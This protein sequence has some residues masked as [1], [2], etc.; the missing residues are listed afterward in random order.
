MLRTITWG[1][2]KGQ[3]M[4]PEQAA[5]YNQQYP[6]S[7]AEY[8]Q[9]QQANGLSNV[10]I[11]AAQPQGSTGATLGPA[12]A[13]PKAAFDATKNA[14]V[15]GNGD[16]TWNSF[17]QRAS[18][19]P[20]MQMP[21]LNAGLA[22]NDRLQQ[23]RVIQELQAQAAGNMNSQA[24][25]QLG[26]GYQQAR[27][28]QSSLGSS[29]RGQSAGAAQRGIMQG[30]QGLQRGFAGDQQ[31]LK[32][33]EQQA[34]QQA[35]QQLLAQQYGQDVN[36]ANMMTQGNL[37]GQALNQAMREFYQNSGLDRD[38]SMGQLRNE[39]LSANAGFDLERGD[40]TR[41]NVDRG[42][43]AAS[44]GLATL[45]QLGVNQRTPQEQKIEDA[46]ND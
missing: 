11:A 45:A 2:A 10:S 3:Q 26:Q 13:D 20:S 37:Q 40:L 31:M 27:A 36:Q 12:V 25:Q 34:A 1:P 29:I 41:R 44:T 46:F 4:T 7:D 21:G 22:N 32:L 23:Q 33:Q 38:L 42:V 14:S 5:A 39:E 15:L 18:G 43:N 35:L 6:A 24:Q 30:Q 19:A 16:P 9:Y 28:Q 8:A 17:F